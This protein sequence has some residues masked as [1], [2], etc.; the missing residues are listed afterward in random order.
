[1][2]MPRHCL[3]ACVAN[4]LVLVVAADYGG[5]GGYEGGYGARSG[6][7]RGKGTPLIHH[8]TRQTKLSHMQIVLPSITNLTS[9]YYPWGYNGVMH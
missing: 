4:E 6:A 8:T 5:Y 2:P 3:P 1:M 7:L 9:L